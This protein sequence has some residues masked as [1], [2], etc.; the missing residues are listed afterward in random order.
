MQT[1]CRIWSD[2]G[3]ATGDDEMMM[4]MIQEMVRD[5]GHTTGDGQ[6]LWILCTRYKCS[7]TDILQ[8]MVRD[9]KFDTRDG[10]R[11][12]TYYRT[13]SKTTYVM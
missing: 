12:G 4:D 6:G 2:Y 8:E 10:Q 1:C 7:V 11:Q 5:C 3:H 9:Y 13:W